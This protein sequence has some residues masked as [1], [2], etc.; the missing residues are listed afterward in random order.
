M[1]CFANITTLDELKREF[2]RLA[3]LHHP[4]RGGDTRTMQIIITLEIKPSPKRK[5]KSPAPQ[6][7]TAQSKSKTANIII[8][9]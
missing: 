3:M 4:D 9:N 5:K 1:K 6:K 7:P 8:Q 2:R